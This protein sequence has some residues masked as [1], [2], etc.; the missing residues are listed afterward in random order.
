MPAGSTALCRITP[1]TYQDGELAAEQLRAQWLL[2]RLQLHDA[3]L[4]PRLLR[5]GHSVTPSMTLGDTR[6]V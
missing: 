2:M 4:E 6:G 1:C 5:Q 3:F